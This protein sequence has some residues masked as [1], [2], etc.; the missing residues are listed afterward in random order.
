VLKV[1]KETVSKFLDHGINACIGTDSMASNRDL[2]ILNELKFAREFYENISDEE[3]LKIATLNG[4]KALGFS[5]ICG[6]IERGKDA[7]LIYFA[8]PSDLKKNEIYR[9]IFHSS[10]CFKL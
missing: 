4:A 5:D 2:N 6:S 10:T 3:L 9:F 8:I 7:D 1:V